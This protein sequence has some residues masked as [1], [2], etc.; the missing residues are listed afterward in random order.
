MQS[1]AGVKTFK[2]IKQTNAGSTETKTNTV[3]VALITTTCIIV[4]TSEFALIWDIKKKYAPLCVYLNDIVIVHEL[5][6]VLWS[7]L[8]SYCT[9]L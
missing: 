5:L 2:Y 3:L 8:L 9:N 6:T 4:N 7:G 1:A